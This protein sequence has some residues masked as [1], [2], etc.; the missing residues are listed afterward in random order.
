MEE[1]KNCPTYSLSP[2]NCL[3]SFFSVSVVTLACDV[4]HHTNA[5]SRERP[6]PIPQLAKNFVLNA[7]F[8]AQQ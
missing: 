8:S 1:K 6:Q 2:S 5:V 7:D 3:Y 4:N